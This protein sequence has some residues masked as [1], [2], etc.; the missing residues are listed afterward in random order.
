MITESE[1]EELQKHCAE[2]TPGPWILRSEPM[3]FDGPEICPG[4]VAQQGREGPHT[5]AEVERQAHQGFL[6]TDAG[7]YPP[8]Q[9]AADLRFIAA[10]RQA[11]PV[12][13]DEIR[14]LRKELGQPGL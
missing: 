13:L 11:L 14:Q 10:A 2:A 4:M 5:R 9:Q 6:F 7:P 12:L 8:E 1:I 3:E